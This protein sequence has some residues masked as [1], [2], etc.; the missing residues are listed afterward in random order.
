MEFDFSGMA[1]TNVVEKP[2]AP[3]RAYQ[4]RAYPRARAGNTYSAKGVTLGRDACSINEPH[5][6][7]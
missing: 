7:I 5:P 4:P 6:K 2:A 3:V 1:P